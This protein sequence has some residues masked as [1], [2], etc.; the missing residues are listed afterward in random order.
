MDQAGLAAE[1]GDEAFDD[2][3]ELFVKLL[4]SHN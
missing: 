3:W 2:R 4:V 1:A